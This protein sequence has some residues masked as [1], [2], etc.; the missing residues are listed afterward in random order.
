MNATDIHDTRYSWLRLSITLAIGLVT[1]ASMWLVVVIMPTVEIE[2]AITRAETSL[3]YTLSMVGFGLG[4]FLIGHLVDRVGIMVALISAAIGITTSLIIATLARDIF[5]LA[6]IHF[7]LGLFAAVGFAPLMSDISH[8]FLKW[9]GTALAL[10]ASANYLSGVLW[11]TV[12]AGILAENGWRQV[13]LTLT[14]ITL[15]VIPTAFLLRRQVTKNSQNQ[16]SSATSIAPLRFGISPRI[17][18]FSLGFAGIACCIAMSMP[19]VHIV[20]YCVGLGYGAGAGAEM[21]SL[22]LFGGVVSRIVFGLLSDRLGGV[23]TLLLGSTMQTLGLV[24]YLPYDGLVSLYAIS[25]IF[26]LSQGGIVPSYALIVREYMPAKEAG[27]RVGF[28]LMMTIW[29]M[30]LGGWMS[31]WIYDLSGGYQMAFLN[32]ILWNLMNIGIIVRLF[33]WP[34]PRARCAGQ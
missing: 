34:A 5:E 18:Q 11:P 10:V 21:L 8:W 28:V 13:Y 3:P 32:G 19:Q 27:A 14:V 1:N 24:F 30:A 16:P 4:N 7:I 9:R 25:L 26:G 29:G 17:L 23:Y 31:G 20:S 2:F 33:F 22:M 6:A 15:V 12:L